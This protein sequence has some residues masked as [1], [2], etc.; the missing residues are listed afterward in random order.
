MRC[1]HKKIEEN[2]ELK[3]VCQRCKEVV[4][5]QLNWSIKA[6]S[7]FGTQEEFDKGVIETT[8][9]RDKL[10]NYLKTPSDAYSFINP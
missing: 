8:K 3:L 1:R 2:E 7:E 10:T 6:S 4:F 9:L 5:Q